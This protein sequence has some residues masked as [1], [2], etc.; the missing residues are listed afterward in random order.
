MRYIK[1]VKSW[2]GRMS[3]ITQLAIVTTLILLTTIVLVIAYTYRSSF[4]I[5]IR[6]RTQAE[7]AL[8]ALENQ[9]IDTYASQIDSFSLQM[10]ND[11]KAIQLLS[12]GPTIS[13]T[14]QTYLQSL[15]RTSFFSRNDVVDFHLYLVKQG[16]CYRLS[17]S[18]PNIRVY[19]FDAAE[20]I[21]G[22]NIFTQPPY[23]KAVCPDSTEDNLMIYYRAL[24][25]IETTKPLAIVELHID[26]SYIAQ[27]AASHT[28]SE[29]LCLVDEQDRLLYSNHPAVDDAQIEALRP[30]LQSGDSSHMIREID[31]VPYLIVIDK[32]Q[33][34]GWKL[35]SFQPKALIDEQVYDMCRGSLIIAGVS[36]PV[37][38]VLVILLMSMLTKP[39]SSL[40]HRLRR[41]G[42]GNFKTTADI[43]GCAEINNLA[44]NFNLMI[45][46][47]DELIEQNYIFEINE[48][49]A[50][51]AALE[52]QINPHFLY[53]TLQ[54]ISAEAIVNGQ[55]QINDM[56]TSLAAL[57]RYSIK[58]DVMV[59][60]KQEIKNVQDYLFLQKARYDERLTYE[61]I[62]DEETQ[63]RRVP[64]ICIQTLVENS[65]IH[66][67]ENHTGIMHLRI[68]AGL[69]E[70]RVLKIVVSDNGCGIPPEQL[71]RL[72][73]EL[74][75]EALDRADHSIGLKNLVNRLHIL[76]HQKALL[77]IS[78]IPYEN[79]S[80][81]LLI[82]DMEV[83]YP[84]RESSS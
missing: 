14:D 61:I 4:A 33:T 75:E 79:T 37:S 48:K 84:S 49:T 7:S 3:L 18:S 55:Y 16:V 59:P 10:R 80:V 34:T 57:L 28:S 54:A 13:Y 53:N 25:N 29:I 15:M 51:L 6:Q 66:G 24:I 56:V 46:R 69:C 11:S 19:P 42:N 72:R 63:E 50:R 81:T 68:T 12:T 2:V 62:M 1:K 17:S 47:I 39:L 31:G 67:M 74:E 41:V 70:D 27:L 77:T 20:D 64:K 60:L 30:V 40:A 58:G 35:I 32:S 44:E 8:L 45:R 71:S 9:N 38:I 52:A 36:L 26:N 78:S 21:P 22:Y 23:F 65:I 83:K 76:Y 43:G 5:M 73:R 82:P